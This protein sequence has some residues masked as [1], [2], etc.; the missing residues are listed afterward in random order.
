[1]WYR[2]L[3]YSAAAPQKGVLEMSLA[4]KRT[5][6]GFDHKDIFFESDIMT[7]ERVDVTNGHIYIQVER[8][9]TD[10]NGRPVETFTFRRAITH[11]D[12]AP[13]L[14]GLNLATLQPG[15]QLGRANGYCYLR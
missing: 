2:E 7:V 6:P 14:A 4:A 12:L 3:L 10:D 9:R 8:Q 5:Q 13:N 15:T 1:M 11:D